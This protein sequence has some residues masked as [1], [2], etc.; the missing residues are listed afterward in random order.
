MLLESPLGN[1]DYFSLPLQLTLEKKKK[2]RKKERKKKKKKKKIKSKLEN[3]ICL[4]SGEIMVVVFVRFP[5]DAYISPPS[6]PF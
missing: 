6:P 1:Y 5:Q 3:R 4:I 2:E